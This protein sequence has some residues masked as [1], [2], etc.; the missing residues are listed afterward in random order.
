MKIIKFGNSWKTISCIRYACRKKAR[1]WSGHIHS[2]ET[3]RIAIAGWCSIECEKTMNRQHFCDE[4]GCWG[5]ARI[6]TR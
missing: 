6:R 3:K 4:H 1:R 5:T 2:N